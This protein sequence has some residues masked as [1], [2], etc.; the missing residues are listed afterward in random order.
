MGQRG[1]DAS[2]DA[3]LGEH[4]QDLF[5]LSEEMEI[6]KQVIKGE[7]ANQALDVP[8]KTE[9]TGN[10]AAGSQIALSRLVALCT[11]SLG[12]ASE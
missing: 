6:K 7:G 1:S 3:G 11:P 12:E 2:R 10:R 5:H 4:T 8:R 9:R